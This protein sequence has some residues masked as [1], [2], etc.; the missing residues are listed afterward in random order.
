MKRIIPILFTAYFLFL[1]LSCTKEQSP[2]STLNFNGVDTSINNEDTISLTA[3]IYGKWNLISDFFY[4]ADAPPF[5]DAGDSIY[6]G[7]AADYYNFSQGGNLYRRE[8]IHIDT[9]SFELLPNNQVE[10]LNIYDYSFEQDSLGTFTTPKV[11]LTYTITTLTEHNLTLVAN[12]S[13]SIATPEG[14]FANKIKLCK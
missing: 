8:S 7:T 11:S 4:V 1:I 13:S 9:C 3:S 10:V 2:R 6:V 14:Y 5:F 12:L